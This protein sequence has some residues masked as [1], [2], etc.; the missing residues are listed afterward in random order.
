M[1]KLTHGAVT[2]KGLNPRR[3]E[4]QDCLLA[5]PER[6]IFLVADGVGGRRGGEVAS[7]TIVEIFSRVFSQEQPEDLRQVIE[8]TIDLCNQKIFSEAETTQDLVG[9]ASTIAVLAIDGTRAIVAHV[10]DSRVYRYDEEGLIQL[11][12]DHSEVNEAL[13]S[14]LITEEQAAHH[15]R[16]NVINRAIGAEPEVEP[17]IIEIEIDE[18]T[19]FLIC[20]DGITRHVTDEEIARLM[21]SGRRPE[22]ICDALKDL[23]YTGGAEDNLTAIVVD[24]GSRDY[25][26]EPTRPVQA[27]RSVVPSRP[28]PPPA[29]KIEVDLSAT[30]APESTMPPPAVETAAP[31]QS[32]PAPF[33]A[34]PPAPRYD[35]AVAGS[36]LTEKGG[37]SELMKWSLLGVAL[38]AGLLIGSFFGRPIVEQLSGSPAKIGSLQSQ[39]NQA[40]PGDPEISAAYARF[41]EGFRDEGRKRLNLALTSNPNS[42]EAHYYLGRIDYAEGRFDEA[43]NH[44]NQAARTDPNLPNIQLH[45]AMAYMSIGQMRN[46]RD[47][48]QQVVGATT[49]QPV[50]SPSPAAGAS[51]GSSKPVG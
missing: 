28:V 49:P 44:L 27:P 24:I 35:E 12:E 23:C 33:R 46:A 32:Q 21:K 14:G 17:D 18:K 39:S 42:A 16:R 15:P 34:K 31:G 48:L 22:A 47:I 5:I 4:N 9:M 2:D 36:N 6:G 43:V 41:L 20:S 19:S 50:A 8:N 29:K 40:S 51:P 3:K 45:L 10:G 25:I 38:I 30:S 26:E 7:Q 13:R 1:F 37:I 11:T